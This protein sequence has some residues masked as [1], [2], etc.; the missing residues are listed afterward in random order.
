MAN[1][2]L[3]QFGKDDDSDKVFNGGVEMMLRALNIGK[4]LALKLGKEYNP[5]LIWNE[6]LPVGFAKVLAEAV[7][8]ELQKDKK[9]KP[10]EAFEEK[11]RQELRKL[12]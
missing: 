6:N 9:F 12:V 5:P 10:D 11:M 4:S 3:I 2:Q 1:Y 7:S 8:V